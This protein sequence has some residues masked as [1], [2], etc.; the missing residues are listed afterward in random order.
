MIQQ[1]LLCIFLNCIVVLLRTDD[2]NS[3]FIAKQAVV[4]KVG[5]PRT[6]RG[7][8]D[9]IHQEHDDHKDGQRQHTVGDHL[10]DLIRNGHAAGVLS[11]IAALQQR[12]NVIVAL[13]GDNAL[14]FIVQLLFGHDNIMLDMCYLFL[15]HGKL[16]KY[17]AVALEDL[18]GVPSLLLLGHTVYGSLLD[19]CDRMLNRTREIVRGG[20]CLGAC[21]GNGHLGGLV[22]AGALE[23]RD[24]DNRAAKLFGKRGDVQVVAVLAHHVDHIDG[25]HDRNTKL[26]QL[27]G[28]IQVTLQVR[29]VHDVENDVGTFPYQVVSCNHLFGSIRR[30]R[31]NTG[32]VGQNHVFVLF[33][34]AF[35]FFH[36]D[37]GPVTYK[38]I[39]ARE[40]I[41]QG[42]FTRVGIARK[43]DPDL[44][45]FHAFST[46]RN[47]VSPC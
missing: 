35:L 40:C 18:D 8:R 25:D 46:F 32:Q 20:R 4:G 39:G 2:R 47:L 27:G 29:A 12:C 24:L 28:Q 19:M 43:G 37:A 9:I 15:G 22:N 34:L 38:L 42:R 30:K 13:V 26:G 31:V 33:D 7:H 3:P 5:H 44:V 17:H 6:N 21:G 16:L 23:C 14:G 11:L 41:K 36:G 45:L 1:I 10:V